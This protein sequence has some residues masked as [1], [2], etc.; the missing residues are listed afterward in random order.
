[1]ARNRNRFVGYKTPEMRS[2]LGDTHV[3]NAL[4]DINTLQQSAVA[5]MTSYNVTRENTLPML[6]RDDDLHKLQQVRDMVQPALRVQSYEV[7]AHVKLFINFQGALVPTIEPSR[8]H[9]Q[10]ARVGPLL[11]YI[12][13]VKAV[14]EQ[15]EEVKAVLRWLNRNATPGAIRFYWPTAMKLVK[16]S[17][18]WRELQ[19][20]PSRFSHPAG[21]SDWLQS[22]KDTANTVAGAAMMPEDTPHRQRGS[23]WLQFDAYGQLSTDN[24]PRYHTDQITYNI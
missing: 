16:D 5:L 9:I 15:Y 21:L 18:I 2:S 17:L 8:L 3:D 6:F 19:E 23:M 12:A 13:A 22:L 7:Q 11:N 10:P 14:H 24:P 4:G 1:M 20:V